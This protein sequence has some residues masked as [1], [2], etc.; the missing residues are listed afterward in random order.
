MRFHLVHTNIF[1][2]HGHIMDYV[3]NHY[4]ICHESFPKLLD[5]CPEPVSSFTLDMAIPTDTDHY[6][7]ISEV[8]SDMCNEDTILNF[9]FLPKNLDP[10]YCTNPFDKIVFVTTY[11]EF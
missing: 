7:I 11:T 6:R 9:P 4:N 2:G 1:T 10:E 5:I 8:I 3:T